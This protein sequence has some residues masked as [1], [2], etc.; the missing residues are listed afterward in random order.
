MAKGTQRTGG[1]E[2]AAG[3]VRRPGL[4]VPVGDP[5]QQRS[6]LGLLSG[7]EQVGEVLLDSGE[8][9]RSRPTQLIVRVRGARRARDAIGRI[10]RVGGGPGG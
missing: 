2:P 10:R 6:E 5:H 3:S 9:S 7:G 8:V 4:G 1:K